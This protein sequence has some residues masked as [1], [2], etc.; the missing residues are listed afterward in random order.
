MPELPEVTVYVEALR[1]RIVGRPLERIR[2]RSPSL[3]KTHEPG[4]S[5]VQGRVVLDVDHIGKRI[6]WQLDGDVFLLVHLMGKL[7]RDR[8]L[9]RLLREDWPRT[10]EELEGG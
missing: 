10:L 6:V 4:P 3:L 2:I 8:A 1:P 9:S 5:E 7:L